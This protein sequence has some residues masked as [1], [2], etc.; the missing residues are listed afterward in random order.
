MHEM[1]MLLL[2]IILGLMPGAI[3]GALEVKKYE[4]KK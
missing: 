3:W 1:L 4:N 2:G